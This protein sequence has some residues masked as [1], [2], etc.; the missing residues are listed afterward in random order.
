LES[1]PCYIA[2]KD[3][4][5][6]IENRQLSGVEF[7]FAEMTLSDQF[8]KIHAN[9]EVPDFV[10]LKA[11]GEPGKDDFG[12]ASGLRLVVSQRV[13]DMLKQYGVSHAA[14]ITSY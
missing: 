6:E 8:K 14:S 4:A 10:Q 12:V 13:L 11:V 1:A 5:L 9:R 3:L 2:T 7:Y